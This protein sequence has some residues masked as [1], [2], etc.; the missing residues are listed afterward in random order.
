VSL[1]GITNVSEVSSLS[2]CFETAS[3]SISIFL[4]P[5]PE[6]GVLSAL[7]AT[8][9]CAG[10]G[11]A[12][13]VEF[14]VTGVVGEN[15]VFGVLDLSDNSVVT[16][17]TSPNIN[18][19]SYPPGNYRVVHMA[20]QQGLNLSNVQFPSDLE[21][22][23]DLSNGI[24]VTIDACGQAALTSSPNPTNGPSNVTFSNPQAEYTTLEVYDLKGR[25]V[26]LLFQ[27]EASVGQDYRFE[28]DGSSLPNGI[29]LYRLTTET[30]VVVNK[31]MIAH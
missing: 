22:C 24:V 29:Y 13:V 20:Y 17:Q 30:Q 25:M 14:E 16:S 18:F 21:G 12:S 3:N 31:W 15:S 4:R 9:V 2:G 1:A 19:N 27:G 5:E 26:E 7:T 10:Q 23:F 8:T 28:F 6:G 11:A